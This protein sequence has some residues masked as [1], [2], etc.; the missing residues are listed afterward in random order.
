MHRTHTRTHAHT[1]TRTYTHAHTYCVKGVVLA[2]TVGTC[3]VSGH[4]L[5]ETPTG[6]GDFST[7]IG[8]EHIVCC[9]RAAV[10][11]FVLTKV[12]N[13]SVHNKAKKSVCQPKQ[14]LQLQ[15]CRL[16]ARPL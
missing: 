15:L 8:V 2:E 4:V 9:K 13:N 10:C 3:P 5:Y 16:D 6:K 14:R 1:H 7:A 11:I 12:K